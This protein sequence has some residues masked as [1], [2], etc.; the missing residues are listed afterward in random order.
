[1]ILRSFLVV[2]TLFLFSAAS[3]ANS[4]PTLNWVGCGIS[5]KAYVTDLAK[6]FEDKT[7]ISINIQGG[8]LHQRRACQEDGPLK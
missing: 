2:S 1:M 4:T 3:Y 8:G 6:A 7:N 5:K